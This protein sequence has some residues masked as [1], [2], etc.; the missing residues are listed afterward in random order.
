MTQIVN[1]TGVVGDTTDGTDG[2]A[3]AK[4]LYAR[5]KDGGVVD[6][7]IA[8]IG[9]VNTDADYIKSDIAPYTMGVSGIVALM[10]GLKWG[11]VRAESGVPADGFLGL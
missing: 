11:R 9:A 4:K 6:G 2:A 7:L 8:G 10:I 3:K 1:L 5:Q